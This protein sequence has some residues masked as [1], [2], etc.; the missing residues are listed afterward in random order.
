LVHAHDERMFARA[1]WNG[2]AL[3]DHEVRA[4][5]ERSIN[6]Y[7]WGVVQ[8]AVVE[9]MTGASAPM[10][11]NPYGAPA[12]ASSEKPAKV[13]R[14]K[15]S[16]GISSAPSVGTPPT[17][18]TISTPST[19]STT[20]PDR[21]SGWWAY[22]A[23]AVALGATLASWRTMPPHDNIALGVTI[24]LA[25]ITTGLLGYTIYGVTTAC[26]GCSAWYR[27]ETTS[28]TETGSS[29]YSKQISKDVTDSSG[30]KIGSTTET[31]TYERTS[32][33]YYYQCKHC[34]HTWTGTGS[35]ERRIS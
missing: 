19:P 11:Y 5:S 22:A 8:K 13:K 18:S 1:T 2:T 23:T 30:K 6:A 33:L 21:R 14:S 29:T 31:A 7:Q 28:T 3:S 10:P 15:A 35:S 27:R 26:P 25:I 20:R 17:I 4:G 9:V 32:Y 34:S 12:P 16:R 24:A